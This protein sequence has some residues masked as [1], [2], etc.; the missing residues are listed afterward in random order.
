MIYKFFKSILKIDTRCVRFYF[1]GF[2]GS[3]HIQ[4]SFEFSSF[5]NEQV[6]N[7]NFAT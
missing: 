5:G 3:L 1:I 6:F 4:L 7:M 2:K